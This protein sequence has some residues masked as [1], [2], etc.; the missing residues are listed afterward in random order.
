MAP[1]LVGLLFI[2]LGAYFVV[3]GLRAKA[4]IKT[5]LA[6]EKVVISEE[7]SIPHTPLVDAMTVAAQADLIKKHSIERYGRFT[8]L[9]RDDPRRDQYL[10]GA[11]LRNALNL[12]VL[13][14]GVA[15]LAIG[16]GVFIIL[17]GVF[18]LGFGVP[19]PFL[20]K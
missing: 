19:T 7:A 1:A 3:K 6:D 8:E 12:A 20:L 17:L 14:F 2:S 9:P 18:I 5:G 15:D 11:T 4:D 13:G 10:R 16:T